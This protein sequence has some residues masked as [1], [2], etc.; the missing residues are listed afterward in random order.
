M[1]VTIALLSTAL[2]TPESVEKA[3]RLHLEGHSAKAAELLLP[4]VD[5]DPAAALALGRRGLR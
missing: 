4:R 5:D 3:T 2:G 1:L